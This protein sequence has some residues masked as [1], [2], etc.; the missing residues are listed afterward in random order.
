MIYIVYKNSLLIVY[1]NILLLNVLLFF[2][3]IIKL[4]MIKFLYYK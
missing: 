4:Y 1:K 3:V 2:D